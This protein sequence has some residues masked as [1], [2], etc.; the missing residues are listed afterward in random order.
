LLNI[1]EAA[2]WFYEEAVPKLRAYLDS[3]KTL[4][5]LQDAVGM[6]SK[7]YDI[8]YIVEQTPAEKDGYPRSMIDAPENL[9]RVPTLSHWQI[10]IWYSTGNEDFGGL[11]PREYLRGKSWEERRRIGLKAL[12]QSGV[13]KP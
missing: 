7:G 6:P 1:A 5:E 4:D 12:L 8:H 10:N 13:L 3:P 2:S 11:P 9:V